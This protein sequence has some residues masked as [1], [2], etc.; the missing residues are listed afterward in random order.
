MNISFFLFPLA[1]IYGIVVYVRN[2]LYDI[3]FFKS[4]K[5]SIPSIVVGNLSMGGSGKTPMMLWLYSHLKDQKKIAFLS[6]GYGR[7]TKGFRQVNE[8]S[9]SDEVGDEPLL[10]YSKTQNT[11]TFVCE[12][13]ILG[14]DRIHSL[15]PEVEYVL[16]DDAF[17]HRKLNADKYLL[18]TE[19][20][21]PFFEDFYFPMGNLRDAKN[22]AKRADIII[23][24]KCPDSLQDTEKEIFIKKINPLPHQSV[25][26]A[27]I[28][29]ELLKD[30]FENNNASFPEDC[31]VVSGIANPK[32]FTE[33]VS[34]KT[35]LIK[36][37]NY[38]D[39]HPFSNKDIDSWSNFSDCK[40]II[41]T[42][43]DAIRL[44]EH[45]DYLES[46][47]LKLYSLPIKM[48]ID[49]LELFLKI[50]NSN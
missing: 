26:F 28:E 10:L 30:V 21:A 45:K 23:I 4:K 38:P 14:I 15:Y 22:Q 31:I 29:Y 39:H 33:A 40:T 18:I 2:F 42:E 32:L 20:N 35:K 48:Q 41:T 24:S 6:R 3:Q 17:Q 44:L 13:R 46:K 19:Y 36:H 7:N 34:K 50:L 49:N 37:F 11:L 12:D 43:K 25:F 1:L 47:N 8:M 5:S 27:T 9:T 16:L